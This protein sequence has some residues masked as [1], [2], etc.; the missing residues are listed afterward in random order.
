MAQYLLELYAARDDV[1]AVAAGAARARRAAAELTGE[2]T[3]VRCLRSIFV[4]GD[5]THFLLCEAGSAD[6]AR[7]TARRAGL[8]AA[9]V[10]DA[11]F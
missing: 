2:G 8:G 7:E 1:A 6:A 5:E 3:P 11:I 4:P 10:V 9:R